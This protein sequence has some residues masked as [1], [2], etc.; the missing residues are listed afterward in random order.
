[1]GLDDVGPMFGDRGG[2]SEISSGSLDE[3]KLTLIYL[4]MA[5]DIVSHPS[6]DTQK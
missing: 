1:M 2:L 5:L 3:I 6:L 4:K